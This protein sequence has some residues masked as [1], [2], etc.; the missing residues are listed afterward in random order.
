[1]LRIWIICFGC[2]SSFRLLTN[3]KILNKYKS[4][5]IFELTYKNTDNIKYKVNI[6]GKKFIEKNKDKGSIIYNSYEFELKEYFEDIDNN[7]HNDKIKFLLCLDKSI[8]DI[9]YLFYECK[10]LISVEFYKINNQTNE[11]DQESIS[12]SD[13][14]E[15]NLTNKKNN[16]NLDSSGSFYFNESI[17]KEKS[18]KNIYSSFFIDENFQI[19][20]SISFFQLTNMS[21]MFYACSSLISLPD[22]SK[23]DTSNVKDMHS[24]FYKCIS[25]KSLP[26][27]SNWNTKNVTDMSYM[28]DGCFCL[29]SLP[30]ISEWDINNATN[31]EN[32]FHECKSLI[33]LPNISKWDINN[34]SIKGM[35]NGCCSLISLPDISNWLTNRFIN[36]NSIVFLY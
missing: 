18:N 7:N 17:I 5:I 30:D 26:N 21:Y 33:S 27:I 12:L 3:T 15:A 2:K 1:M 25:L 16:E 36:I 19:S 6:L 20:F 22:I 9:S 24:L 14:F 35:F 8:N 4:N 11:K 13:D 29:I 28:L 31:M 23:W 34:A 32:M 10:K